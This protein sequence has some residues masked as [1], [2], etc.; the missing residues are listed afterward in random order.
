MGLHLQVSEYIFFH[1]VC[2]TVCLTV[3]LL[4]GV[5]KNIQIEHTSLAFASITGKK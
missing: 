1:G 2:G 5:F 4:K 3:F